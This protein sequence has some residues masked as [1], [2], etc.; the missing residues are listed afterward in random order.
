MPRPE[1]EARFHVVAVAASAG[2]FRPLMT[3]AA[4]LPADFPAAVL[5]AHHQSTRHPSQLD[6]LLARHCLLPVTVAAGGEALRPGTLMLAPP[7]G[8][9]LVVPGWRLSTPRDAPV[10]FV[11]PSADRLFASVAGVIRSRAIA[12]VLSGAGHDGAEGVR[13]VGAAGGTVIVQDGA[14]AQFRSMPDS[15]IGTGVA[16]LILP[17]DQIAQALLR[18]VHG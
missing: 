14:T 3:L 11:R 4:G 1:P 9:L 6:G 10:R 2:A 15:A 7:G 18:L 17:P 12:I 5:I 16:H 13:A 8:H